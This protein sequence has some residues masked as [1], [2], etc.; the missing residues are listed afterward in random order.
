MLNNCDDVAQAFTTAGM[1]EYFALN[2]SK[3]L[4]EYLTDKLSKASDR[5]ALEHLCQRLTKRYVVASPRFFSLCIA[6]NAHLLLQ[7]RGRFIF[8]VCVATDSQHATPMQQ[9]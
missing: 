1:I 2:H 7:T 3:W 9:R 5:S 4:E 8:Q 6:N